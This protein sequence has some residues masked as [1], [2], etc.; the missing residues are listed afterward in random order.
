MPSGKLGTLLY[1]DEYGYLKT[2]STAE[3]NAQGEARAFP[4]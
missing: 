4:F 2:V 1:G 3:M